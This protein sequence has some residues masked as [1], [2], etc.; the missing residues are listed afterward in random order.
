MRG[1]RRFPLF[2][3]AAQHKHFEKLKIIS[4]TTS[5]DDLR[6]QFKNG[7]E[8]HDIQKVMTR[9]CLFRNFLWNSMNMDNLDTID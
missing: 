5:G 9:M 2:I 8:R 4:G 7:C 1:D 3:R 6:V